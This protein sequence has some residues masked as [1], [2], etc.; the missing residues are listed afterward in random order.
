MHNVLVVEDDDSLRTDLVDYLTAKGFQAAGIDCAEALR[1][2]LDQGMPDVILLDVGLPDC[3][4]F[5]LAREIRRQRKLTCGIIMLTGFGA[6]DDRVEGLESGA[7]V[8]LVKHASL[9]EIDATVRSLLR[10]LSPVTVPSPGPSFWRLDRDHWTLGAPNGESVE[11]TGTEM[12][13][14]DILINKAG[15]VCTRAE[16]VEAM[17]RPSMRQ[18]DR[19]LDSVIRRLRRKIEQGCHMAPPI[20]MVYGSGYIFTAPAGVFAKGKAVLPPSLPDADGPAT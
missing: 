19:N 12:G 20:R 17:G 16:L 10:R 15:V 14:L 9:R 18:D 11:L 5:D 4:G 8:Y 3:H 1:R 6:V 2:A 7:D 13:F